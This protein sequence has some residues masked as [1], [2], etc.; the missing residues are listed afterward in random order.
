MKKIQT[1]E[2]KLDAMVV[3]MDQIIENLS[4]TK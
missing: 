4:V 1:L 3:K 2:E